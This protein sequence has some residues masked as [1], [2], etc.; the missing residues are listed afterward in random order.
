MKKQHLL[1]LSALLAGLSCV[2]P[3]E[4]PIE[5][6]IEFTS[7]NKTDF[8]PFDPDSLYIKFYFE[9]GDG[10]LGDND[11]VNLFFHDSRLPDTVG[12]VNYKIPFIELQ[13][14]SDAISG[15]VTT[16]IGISTCYEHIGAIDTFHYNVFIKDRAGHASNTIGTPD[17]YLDCE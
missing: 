3:P 8:V 17:L 13:G 9:D 11:S 15:Y 14:S 12:T 5:P 16:A 6:H 2:K 7:V 10:D 4:Y 1:V